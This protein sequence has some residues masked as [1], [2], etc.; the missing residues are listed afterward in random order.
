MTLTALLSRHITV[1]E[2]LRVPTL[3]EKIK[4]GN[5]VETANSF[6]FFIQF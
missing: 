1:A 4:K 6:C 2:L 3:K 5:A